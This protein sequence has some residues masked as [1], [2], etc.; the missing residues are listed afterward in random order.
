MSESQSQPMTAPAP[1]RERSSSAQRPRTVNFVVDRETIVQVEVIREHSDGSLDLRGKMNQ[2]GWKT[3]KETSANPANGQSAEF[4]VEV[5][6]PNEEV[7]TR[8]RVRPAEEDAAR[9][10]K[11]VPGT[12]FE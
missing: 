12:W 11:H 6:D 4:D 1:A 5:P 9:N 7:V 8:L 3:I 2:H 10:G